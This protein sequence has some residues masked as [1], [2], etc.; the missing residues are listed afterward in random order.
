MHPFFV[1]LGGSS[2]YTQLP[3]A[4]VRALP[5]WARVILFIFTIPG[6][7]LVVLSLFALGVSIL[8][9]LLC[10]V[11]VYVLLKK[12]TGI[13]P[14]SDGFASPGARRVEATIRDA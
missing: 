1:N 12:V 10:T 9:L 3:L 7:L 6:I 8:A 11:P 5:K 4:G 13:R 2:A 14:A